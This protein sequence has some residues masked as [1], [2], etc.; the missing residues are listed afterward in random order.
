VFIQKE[1]Y[2]RV[3]GFN[4]NCGNA[5]EIITAEFAPFT[6]DVIGVPV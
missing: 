4:F 5:K 3:G 6:V 2:K 1:K